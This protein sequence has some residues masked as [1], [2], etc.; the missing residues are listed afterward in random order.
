MI[1]ITQAVVVEGKYDK[2]KLSGLLDA[3]IVVT[4]GFA[5]FR[6]KERMAYLRRLARERGL[7]VLT[8]S[9]SA[10]QLIRNHLQGCIPA[11]QIKHGYIPA[12]P[13]KEKRKNAPSKEGTLGV[14]GMEASLLLDVIEKSGVSVLRQEAEEE[15]KITKAMLF[16]DGLTGGQNSGELRGRLLRQMGLPSFLTVNAL[17]RYL[18]QTV[19]LEEYRQLI[20]T[21]KEEGR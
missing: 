3:E 8:D 1:K 7:L 14:E 5:I 2:I 20:Q 21:I 19:S 18:N 9:D 16:S 6:D 17:L 11:H 12:L 4:N 10:G 15:P 13:G